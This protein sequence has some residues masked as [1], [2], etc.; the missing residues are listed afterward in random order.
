[1][2]R[3]HPATGCYNPQVDSKHSDFQ[4]RA[5]VITYACDYATGSLSPLAT[6][7][8]VFYNQLYLPPPARPIQVSSLNN[9]RALPASGLVL[10][11]NFIHDYDELDDYTIIPAAAITRLCLRLQRGRI[12]GYPSPGAAARGR[13]ERV[14]D[15]FFLQ[16]ILRGYVG[17]S[18]RVDRHQRF[19]RPHYRQRRRLKRSMD[20]AQ[21]NYR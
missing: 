14:S 17:R 9:D 7:Y 3:H 13:S 15:L 2:D 18:L 20:G 5:L 6:S 19:L 12:T 8:T 10:L 4:S 16:G 1:M 11:Y 21:R